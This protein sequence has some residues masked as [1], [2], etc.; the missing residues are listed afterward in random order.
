MFI[1]MFLFIDTYSNDM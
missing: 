1:K